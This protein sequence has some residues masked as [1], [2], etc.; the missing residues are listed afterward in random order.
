[1]MLTG[2][3]AVTTAAFMLLNKRAR[4][5]HLLQPDSNSTKLLSLATRAAL[6]KQYDRSYMLFFKRHIWKHVRS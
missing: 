4:L 3:S 6:R 1:M 2:D 5:A